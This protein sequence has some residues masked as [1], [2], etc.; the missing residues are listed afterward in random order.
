MGAHQWHIGEVLRRARLPTAQE[1]SWLA[2]LACRED[3]AAAQLVSDPGFVRRVKVA[4]GLI[5]APPAAVARKEP[6]GECL[7]W[8]R[9]ART[10]HPHIQLRIAC[11][12]LNQ[13]LVLHS[14]LPFFHCCR[15]AAG[16]AGQAQRAASQ[17][18]RPRHP[19]RQCARTLA[20]SRLAHRQPD[21]SM[22]FCV[23]QWRL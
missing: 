1:S 22:L 23:G 14:A 12:L 21:G 3:E 10:V 4:C 7:P 19:G 16:W 9:A 2:C 18:H 5:A 6:A 11:A 13:R 17:A 15:S 20:G 8:P